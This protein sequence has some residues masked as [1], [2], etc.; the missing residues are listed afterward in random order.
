MRISKMM[1]GMLVLS[2][3]GLLLAGGME[4]AQAQPCETDEFALCMA[5][6]WARWHHLGRSVSISGDTA[7]AGGHPDDSDYGAPGWAYVYE[8]NHGGLGNWGEVAKLTPSDGADGDKFGWSVS[9]SG[10]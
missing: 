6:D 5:S 3:A 8:R 4:I 1:R 7:V 10:D 2:T 9:I